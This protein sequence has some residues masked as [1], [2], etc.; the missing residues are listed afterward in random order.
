LAI[1]APTY[2]GKTRL[3]G[4]FIEEIYSIIRAVFPEVIKQKDV[5]EK[6]TKQCSDG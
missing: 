2:E 6:I 4:V 1:K 5:E 3:Q